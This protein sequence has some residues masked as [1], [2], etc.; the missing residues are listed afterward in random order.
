VKYIFTAVE[1]E[2]VSAG[3]PN[4]IPI[5]VVNLIAFAMQPV[6]IIVIGGIYISSNICGKT[7]N[8]K[9]Y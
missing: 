2:P 3:Q 6:V 8:R 9:N 1:T 5:F 7:T 4:F